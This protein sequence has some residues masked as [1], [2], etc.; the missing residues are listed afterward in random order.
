MMFSVWTRA[1]LRVIGV[2]C[3]IAVGGAI[4]VLVV[5][6]NAWIVIVLLTLLVFVGLVVLVADDIMRKEGRGRILDD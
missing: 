1:V 3:A 2:I 5:L 4:F 6:F